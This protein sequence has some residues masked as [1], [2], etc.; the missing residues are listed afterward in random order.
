MKATCFLI[1]KA[2]VGTKLEDINNILK[3]L[4]DT[5]AGMTVKNRVYFQEFINNMIDNNKVFII[6]KPKA[7]GN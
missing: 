2:E 5:M 7:A 4:R 3:T 1:S 6:E